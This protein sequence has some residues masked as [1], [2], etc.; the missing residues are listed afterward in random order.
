MFGTNFKSNADGITLAALPIGIALGG[1]LYISGKDYIGL[2]G[3][4]SW[5]IAP[6]KSE[7]ETKSENYTVSSLSTGAFLDVDGYVYLG[8]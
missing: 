3:F 7:G 5:T 6:Q 2:S 1:Q 4:G 8:Y